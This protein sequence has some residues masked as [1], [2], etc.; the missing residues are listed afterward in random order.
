MSR[1]I[2]PWR[3]ATVRTSTY[4]ISI[5]QD[6]RHGDSIV[7]TFIRIGEDGEWKMATML[8]ARQRHAYDR[9]NPSGPAG[10][11]PISTKA[12]PA[13]VPLSASV[14]IPARTLTTILDALA[15][16]GLERVALADINGVVSE[17]GASIRKFETL[18]AEP[19]RLAQPALYAL[20]V[21]RCSMM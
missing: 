12:L 21:K 11:T 18:A 20:I 1:R 4:R 13:K 9:A 6:S 19:R 3:A 16:A 5:W 15:P 7:A 2:P 8:T 10:V 14:S 17:L